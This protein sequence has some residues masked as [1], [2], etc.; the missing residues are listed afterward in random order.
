MPGSVAALLA[1]IEGV[2]RDASTG[3]YRR[4]AWTRE[5]AALAGWF[6]AACAAR[7]LDLVTDRCGNQ[8]AWWGDP[9]AALAAG[10]GP[11]VVTG[12]HLDSVPQGG[13]YDGPLGLACAL[14]ALD[15]LRGKGF[16][17]ARPIG[18]VRFVDE[19]GA[20]F[21]LACTGSR[22]LTG[23][24]PPERVLALRDAGGVS[25]AEAVAGAGGDPGRIG[26]DEQVLRRVGGFVELHVE[27]GRGLADLGFGV[28]VG[29]MIRP[30][31]RW[32]VDLAGRADHAGTTLLADR[33]DPML[34]LARL[35]LAVRE[36]A[37]RRAALAT[38]G[39][40]EVTPNAVNAVP[41]RVTAWLDVRA[42]EEAQARRV[43]GDLATA[44]F[45]AV[46]ESWTPATWMDGPLS[47][48][49]AARV[50]AVQGG[51]PRMATG[52]GH[53]AGIL[54]AAGIPAAMLFVRNP[55][56]I[57]HSPA[58]HAEPEDCEAGAVVLADVLADLSSAPAASTPASTSSDS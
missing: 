3:G 39:R 34:D 1:E 53:D 56:G 17:P 42:E 8:W 9:D 54:A 26:R 43:L 40:V 30:H 22:L 29:T 16:T 45:G 33:R 36:S 21:G 51:A 6:A 57:S 35:V 24:A 32:R 55:T 28:G 38:V 46:E 50:A 58:E 7:G 48:R 27:Q 47:E 20:R 18:V 25:Y 2:G 5:D 14:A 4:F 37:V 10:T 23:T 11:G 31:G 44:G 19:E 12:S 52:A 41:G 13:A 49:V 15:R